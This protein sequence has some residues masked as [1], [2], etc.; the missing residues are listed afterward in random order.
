MKF[1]IAYEELQSM[2]CQ[3]SGKSVKVHADN[4]N[5]TVLLTYQME[6]NVPILGKITKDIGVS[7]AFNGIKDTDLDISYTLSRGMNL[8]AQGVRIFLN[9]QIERT[10]L[11][12][13]GTEENQVILNLEKLAEKM[14]IDG[15]DRITNMVTIKDIHATAEGIE[16]FAVLKN[17]C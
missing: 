13:W 10:G 11:M 2:I 14:H 6:V 17:I 1:F 3:K 16:V 5:D 8:V 15:V 4:A 7:V 12:R 9:E